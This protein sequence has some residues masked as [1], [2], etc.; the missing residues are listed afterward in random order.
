[1]NHQGIVTCRAIR[2]AGS[3][4]VRNQ[5]LPQDHKDLLLCYSGLLDSITKWGYIDLNYVK[6]CT[7]SHEEPEFLTSRKSMLING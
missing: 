2:I 3:I 4:Y 7:F 5:L 1:M 6:F